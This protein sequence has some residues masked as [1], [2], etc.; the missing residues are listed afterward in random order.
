VFIP[1]TG[2]FEKMVMRMLP[3]K[4]KEKGIQPVV[5]HLDESQLNTPSVAIN[6]AQTEMLRMLQI[7]SK[8]TKAIIIPFIFREPKYDEKHPQLL[9]VSAIR[10]REEK[11]DFLQEKISD[12]LFQISRYE[13][14]E[15]QANEV[16]IL[17][18]ITEDMES[19][20][21]VIDKNLISLLDK[22]EILREDFSA[23]GKKEITEFHTKIMKQFSRI[24]EAF[25]ELDLEKA[26]KVMRKDEKYRELESN[27]RRVH[28]ERVQAEVNKS[29]A[30]HEIHMELMDLLKQISVYIGN[31]AKTILDMKHQ[32]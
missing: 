27:F 31:I 16:F 13:L 17:I 25:S 10:M 32:Q 12:Y 21:D 26:Q 19:I 23:N 11:I 15:V 24:S 3:N 6:L 30:T 1:F 22:W 2:I 28:L 14:T 29:V 9:H 4:P 7:L 18:S 20:G 8:M 5:W